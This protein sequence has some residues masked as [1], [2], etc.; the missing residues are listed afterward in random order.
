M[1]CGMT[2]ETAGFFSLDASSDLLA[3]GALAPAQFR[4]ALSFCGV[5]K[6]CED[7]TKHGKTVICVPPVPT[8]CVPV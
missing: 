1:M 5:S 6:C 8:G 2:P 4:S 7:N 3:I